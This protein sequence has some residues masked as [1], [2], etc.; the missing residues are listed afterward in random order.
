MRRS[1]FKQKTIC[2]VL[3]ISF[4][5]QSCVI[6][7]KDSISL[8]EAEAK[9]QKTLIINTDNSKHKY[10][11]IIQIDSQYYGEIKKDSKYDKVLLP[12]NEIK[13]IYTM[14]KSASKIAN[15]AIILLTMGGI[16]IIST[17]DFAPDFNIDGSGY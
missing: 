1:N 3:A 17:L 16:I 12:E 9:N 14:D 5:L 2:A 13:N 15:V 10:K 11:R 7:K 8:K 6:Y 4:S